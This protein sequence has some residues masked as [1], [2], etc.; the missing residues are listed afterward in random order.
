MTQPKRHLSV[1]LSVVTLCVPGC[2]APSPSVVPT[3]EWSLREDLSIGS[4]EGA[5]GQPAFGSVN[6]VVGTL[7]G[8]VVI[9]DAQG[10]RVARFSSAGDFLHDLGG[11]GDGPGE[12]L[13]VSG[14]AALPNGDFLVRDSR[15]GLLFFGADGT[16]TSETRIPVDYV[17]VDPVAV[18]NGAV[19][20][21]TEGSSGPLNAYWVAPQHVFVR[22]RLETGAIDT[23]APLEPYR[24]ADLYW[25]PFQPRYHI[26]WRSDGS[27]VH[28]A[29]SADSLF[30]VES[31]DTTILRLDHPPQRLPLPD[32]ARR[33]IEE[34]KSW[35]ENRGNR[36]APYFPEPPAELP[37]FKRVLISSEDEVWVQRPVA[38]GDGQVTYRM[39]VFDRR[40][41][42]VGHLL[43]PPGLEG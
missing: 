9:V 31:N 36:S 10:P 16:L 19:L 15:K 4:L 6:E 22:V 35:L 37:S 28:G 29:G 38:A 3:S 20:I 43:I 2:E 24:Q 1:L 27:F 21:R 39:D 11:K 26:A 25:A 5:D 32:W 7:T 41:G 8:G 12:Y 17:G 30:L 18:S 42:L 40:G 14:I 23:L 13:D 34:H 33:E